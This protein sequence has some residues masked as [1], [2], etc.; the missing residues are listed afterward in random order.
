MVEHA[1]F[2]VVADSVWHSGEG[3]TYLKGQTI[4]LPANT[5]TTAESS[6]QPAAK[7]KKPKPEK[8]DDL[9]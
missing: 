4:I 3:K 5:K 2:I 7:A 8:S 1:D 9:V 6:V